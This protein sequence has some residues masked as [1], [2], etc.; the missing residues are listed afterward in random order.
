MQ[1]EYYKT[2]AVLSINRISSVAV[3]TTS[4]INRLN[5]DTHD[6]QNWEIFAKILKFWELLT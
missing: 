3:M 6:K 2:E 5:H 1:R 4:G